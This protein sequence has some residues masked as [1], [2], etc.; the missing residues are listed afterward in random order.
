MEKHCRTGASEY[1][2]EDYSEGDKSGGVSCE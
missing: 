1:R 2:A